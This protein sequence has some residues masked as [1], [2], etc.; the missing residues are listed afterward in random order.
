MAVHAEHPEHVEQVGD[1][2]NTVTGGVTHRGRAECGQELQQVGDV[3][4]TAA[5]QVLD[6]GT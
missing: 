6:A 4:P 3:D 2:R 5:V 1:V